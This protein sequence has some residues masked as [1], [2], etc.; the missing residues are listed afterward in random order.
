MG[1]QARL[2]LALICLPLLGCGWGSETVEEPEFFDILYYSETDFSTETPRDAEKAWVSMKDLPEVEFVSSEGSYVAIVFMHPFSIGVFDPK[3]AEWIGIVTSIPEEGRPVK[4]AV[5]RL[6][7]ESMSLKKAHKM[8]LPAG[9]LIT[10]AEA[11]E[12]ISQNP[13]YGWMVDWRVDP[14][15]LVEFGGNYI[16]SYMSGDFGGVI[17]LNGYAGKIIFS[18]TRVWNGVGKVLVPGE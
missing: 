11:A 3:A 15:D 1:F 18:A 9:E 4:I 17:V 5:L 10:P 13:Q 16:Y 12:I 8:Q 6:D 2:F 7:Y 14:A